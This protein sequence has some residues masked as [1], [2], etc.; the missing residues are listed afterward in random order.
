MAILTRSLSRKNFVSA[1]APVGEQPEPTVIQL[2]EAKLKR[3][4]AEMFHAGVRLDEVEK[5]W[6]DAV[7]LGYLRAARGE[8]WGMG[9]GDGAAYLVSQGEAVSL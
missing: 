9:Y 1:V 4:G 8:V 2:L 3:V 5:R 7:R 6:P